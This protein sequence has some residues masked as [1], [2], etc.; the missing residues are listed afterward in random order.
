MK[1]IPTMRKPLATVDLKNNTSALAHFERSDVCAVPSCAI[2]ADARVAII[3]AD[4]LL[5][6]FG[7]D[8][9]AEMKAHYGK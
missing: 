6:K 3:L 8:S 9:L 5:S 4:E 1:A 2:V 7:G